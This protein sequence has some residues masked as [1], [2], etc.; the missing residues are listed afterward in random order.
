[1]FEVIL[2]TETTGLSFNSDKIIEIACIELKNQI[3]TKN[4]FHTFI[5]PE[6]DISDGAYQT[7]GITRQFLRD[8]PTFKDIAKDFLNFIKDSKLIIHNADFDLAF[9]NKELQNCDLEPLSK[10][11]VVD[12]LFLARQKFPGAQASLD[13][14][15]KRFKID[16]SAREKHSAIVDCNLLT[17]VYIELL[18]KKEPWLD[19]QE[20]KET[21]D[22]KNAPRKINKNRKQIIL[23][24]TEE[25]IRLHQEFLK[26]D[27]PKSF[28]LK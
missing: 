22:E 28:M 6:M 1:M 10:D 8:K 4:K 19:L 16:T 23:K 3:P 17:E 11:R 18:D 13:A 20:T 27:V 7:H 25:E 2:D 14:L 21:I 9:L 15:C 5:N 24:A 12:T 26:S